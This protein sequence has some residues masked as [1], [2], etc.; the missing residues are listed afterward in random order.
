MR[1]FPHYASGY[2]KAERTLFARLQSDGDLTTLKREF[3]PR[4]GITAR[5]FNSLAAGLKGMIKSIRERQSGL[6]RELEQRIA[7]AK[8][9]VK[10]I[11]DPAR[12]HQ[13][14]RR[15]G[16]LQEHLGTMKADRKVG[17]VRLCFGSRK[18][19]RSPFHLK[20]NR[21]ASPLEWLW[22]WKAT[23]TA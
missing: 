3:L 7:K 2:G 17:K 8:R 21:Y 20:D 14:Q 12:K 19:F 23:R 16:I 13:K 10:R 1:S 18:L 11:V 4:F 15:I 5:Q 22:E 9:V 6:I